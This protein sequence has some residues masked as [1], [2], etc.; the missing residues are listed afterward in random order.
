[1]V[2]SSLPLTKSSGPTTGHHSKIQS[3]PDNSPK[4]NK[5]PNSSILSSPNQSKIGPKIP[6]KLEID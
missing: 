4:N 3:T 6:I 5:N 2:P 1:L